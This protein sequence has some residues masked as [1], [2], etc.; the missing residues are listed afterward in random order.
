MCGQILFE[1]K[2]HFLCFKGRIIKNR[3]PSYISEMLIY[4]VNIKT[5]KI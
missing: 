1:T 4:L 2:N 5:R 3:V